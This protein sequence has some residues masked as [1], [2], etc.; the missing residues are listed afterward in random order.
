LI[1][2]SFLSAAPDPKELKPTEAREGSQPAE[3]GPPP[4]SGTSSKQERALRWKERAVVP[5][6]IDSWNTYF[7]GRDPLPLDD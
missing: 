7:D 3:P 1:S 6:G 4:Q 2:V 5:S